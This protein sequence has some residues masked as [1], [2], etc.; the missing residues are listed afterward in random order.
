MKWGFWDKLQLFCHFRGTPT[1]SMQISDFP[2]YSFIND[3]LPSSL[4][5]LVF[6]KI[7]IAC[8]SAH[9]IFHN[10]H[11]LLQYPQFTRWFSF[12]MVSHPKVPSYRILSRSMKLM[13]KLQSLGFPY[14]A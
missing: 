12:P 6:M 7:L 9:Q 4:Y 11:N 13:V 3:L 8:P 10:P 1:L 14:L 5:D 2:I